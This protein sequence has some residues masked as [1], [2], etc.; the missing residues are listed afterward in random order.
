[1]RVKLGNNT[2]S[3]NND[4]NINKRDKTERFIGESII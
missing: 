1:M 2:T 3:I 4:F